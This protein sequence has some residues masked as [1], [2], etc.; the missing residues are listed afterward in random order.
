MITRDVLDEFFAN[1]R[2][3]HADGRAEFDI[4]KLCRWSF[5][6]VDP[7]EERLLAI[8]PELAELGYEIYG[9]L[10]PDANDQDPVYF[11]RV[12]KIETHTVETLLARNEQLYAFAG[13]H[14]VRDYDGMDVGAIDGP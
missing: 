9:T 7:S 6:F 10:E 14:G 13:A 8:A 4:D 11:L 3:L 1:T 12:D 5:F 2:K